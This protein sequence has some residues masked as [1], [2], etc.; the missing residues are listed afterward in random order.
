MWD[1]DHFVDPTI[2]IRI[3][4]AHRTTIYFLIILANLNLHGIDLFKNICSVDAELRYTEDLASLIQASFQEIKEKL[5]QHS[6]SE[7][8]LSKSKYNHLNMSA[9]CSISILGCK[10]KRLGKEI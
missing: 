9:L 1:V 3:S 2:L 7:D 4:T 5:A 10:E 8:W 6:W